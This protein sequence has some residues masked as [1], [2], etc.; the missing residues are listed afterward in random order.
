MIRCKRAIDALYRS[1]VVGHEQ[2]QMLRIVWIAPQGCNLLRRSRPCP[3]CIGPDRKPVV[4][5]LIVRLP[6]VT[7]DSSVDSSCKKVEML[8]RVA[9][10]PERRNRFLM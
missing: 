1:V 4:P 10:A 8:V 7:Q 5:I 2:I 9:L 3:S 6:I